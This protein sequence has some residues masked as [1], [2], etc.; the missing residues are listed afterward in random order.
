[1]ASIDQFYELTGATFDLL[2]KY[3]GKK[4]HVVSHQGYTKPNNS[5]LVPPTQMDSI[6]EHGLLGTGPVDGYFAAY[7]A[8][9]WGCGDNGNDY[10]NF[11]TNGEYPKHWNHVPCGYYKHKPANWKSCPSPSDNTKRMRYFFRE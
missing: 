5:F 6:G 9:M 1:M 2:I 4:V 3:G 10:L 8:V 7:C 11:S